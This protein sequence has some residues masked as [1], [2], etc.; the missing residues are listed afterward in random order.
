MMEKHALGQL[1]SNLGSLSK[2]S[3]PALVQVCL[4]NKTQ[5]C[6]MNICKF[7]VEY[8]AMLICD[9]LPGMF[10]ILS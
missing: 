8:I 1:A 2:E 6:E 10:C 5:E 7:E 9:F 3:L 4:L